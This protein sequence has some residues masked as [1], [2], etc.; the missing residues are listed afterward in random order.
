MPPDVAISSFEQLRYVTE[1]YVTGLYQ[2]N[3]IGIVRFIEIDIVAI[4]GVNVNRDTESLMNGNRSRLE[5]LVKLKRKFPRLT[6]TLES[7]TTMANDLASAYW[8]GLLVK[9]ELTQLNLATAAENDAGRFWNLTPN[10]ERIRNDAPI[11]RTMAFAAGRA[12]WFFS[13]LGRD[14]AEGDL[15][16]AGGDWITIREWGNL[17]VPHVPENFAM[18]HHPH[19]A[20][21]DVYLNFG[22]G[23]EIPPRPAYYQGLLQPNA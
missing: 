15:N 6:V 11:R 13:E 23:Q 20:W 19:G 5:G 21:V 18:T 12:G 4:T 8:P 14:M 7:H 9:R 2:E 17:A 1:L 10:H 22:N 16:T 3:R